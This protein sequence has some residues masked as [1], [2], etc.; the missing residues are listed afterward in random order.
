[1]TRALPHL[2][3]EL[4]DSIIDF[5]HDDEESL[6]NCSLVCKAFLPVTRF[7]I[8]RNLLLDQW[9]VVGF[10]DLI[11]QSSATVA[12]Y[13]H[14]LAIDQGKSR[15]SDLFQSLLQR[16]PR[17]THL[18][19]LEL[20]NILWCHYS[21]DTI[22]RLIFAFD[23]V[24][25]LKLFCLT[26]DAPTSLRSVITS[27]PALKRLSISHTRFLPEPSH[28]AYGPASASFLKHVELPN[29]HDLEISEQEHMQTVDWFL[30]QRIPVVSLSV[31]LKSFAVPSLNG[32]LQYLGP[33]LL[34]LTIDVV[35][36]RF[37]DE[38]TR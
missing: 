8:F 27:F 2:P 11:T 38:G 30:S 28:L 29:I 33:A 34:D 37:N 32:Y 26:L 3:A 7:H 17:F 15:H 21:A 19:S 24:T 20:R 6:I 35:L 31:F 1:M 22:D 10:I 9:N 5:L 18:R 12:P 23:G 36:D 13:V 16:L 25:E 4:T 14:R